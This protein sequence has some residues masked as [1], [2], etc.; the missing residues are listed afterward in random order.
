[1]RVAEDVV[2]C[3]RERG[4]LWEVADGLTALT[5][6]P[7]QLLHEIEREIAERAVAEC[8]REWR[9][10]AA[11]SLETLARAGYFASFPQWLTM[12]AHLDGDPCTLERIA[13]SSEP[14]A[15]A[16]RH[17]A[18]VAGAL[19]PA[20]CYHAYARLA[21]RTIEAPTM[22][23]MQGTCWRHERGRFAP[24]ER[25]W[26]FTMRE[27]I[28]IGEPRHVESFLAR[29]I[30]H[31][32]A[33]AARFGVVGEIVAATDPFF[34]PTARG[35]ALLQRVKGLKRELLLPIGGGRSIAA[36]SFNDHESFF[37][38]AFDIRLASGEPAATGCVAFGLERWLLA[39]LTAAP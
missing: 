29:G 38:E 28:C 8:G 11:L 18:P 23:T 30:A 24:L 3:L 36:A 10:A 21:G 14:S 27:M 17:A 34:A 37:G 4:D 6:A 39:A 13:E 25:E 7:L 9:P 2:R 32:N 31:A 5:G 1:M 26:A 15:E 22:V 33:L 20:V 35:K 19:S 12:F 16:S